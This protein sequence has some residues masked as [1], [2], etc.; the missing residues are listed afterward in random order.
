[1]NTVSKTIS[2]ESGQTS[3]A[4]TMEVSSGGNRKVTVI[5]KDYYG[6]GEGENRLYGGIASGLTLLPGEIKMSP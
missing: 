6:P 1:M 5:G 4:I 3:P 2:V